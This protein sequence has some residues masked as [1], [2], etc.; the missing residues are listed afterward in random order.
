M[1]LGELGAFLKSRRDRLS[2]ESVGLARALRLD[3]DETGHLFHLAG[4]PA[5]IGSEATLVQHALR[6]L[7]DRLRDTPAMVIT[8][9]HEVVTQNHAAQVLV[10]PQAGLTGVQ[11]GFLHCCRPAAALVRAG[12]RR[13]G[14]GAARPRPRRRLA[15][16]P[17]PGVRAPPRPG[18]TTPGCALSPRAR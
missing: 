6:G 12:R 16:H 15:R 3:D 8:D 18:L 14:G 17:R 13:R 10:G 11:A 1:G 7:L 9:L 4:R 5:P 2:P